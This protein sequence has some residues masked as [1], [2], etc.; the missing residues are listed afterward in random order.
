MALITCPECGKQISDKA[1]NCV[2]CGY[3]IESSK[4]SK[5]HNTQNERTGFWKLILSSVVPGKERDVASLIKQCVYISQA[6][7][8]HLVQKTPSIICISSYENCMIVKN[9]IRNSTLMKLEVQ[10][11]GKKDTGGYEIS[12]SIIRPK[13]IPNEVRCPKCGSLSIATVNRGYSVIW[14][15]IGSSKPMNVCQ[16]CGH[17][18]YP[19]KQ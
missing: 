6:E 8:T 16:A 12:A 15:F 2:H 11:A 10:Q 14:G 13:N 18:F 4:V 3:P 17:K 1:P 7:A 5:Q 9:K 19:G